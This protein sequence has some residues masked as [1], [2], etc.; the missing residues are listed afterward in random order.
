MSVIAGLVRYPDVCS[1]FAR[2][3][4]LER[5]RNRLANISMGC[6]SCKCATKSSITT[7]TS[8]VGA[9]IE[10][11]HA[12]PP[13]IP[14]HGS[15]ETVRVPSYDYFLSYSYLSQKGYYPDAPEKANQDSFCIET[16]LNNN[17]DDHFF[18]VFD[19]HGQFGAQCS[20]FAK[21]FLIQNL[22]KDPNFHSDISEAMFA[23]FR[24][25]N[26][27]L[28][29]DT[30]IDDSMS[31]TT[32]ITVLVHGKTLYVANV[33]DSRAVLA[34][35]RGN[36]LLAMDL[37]CDQTPFRVDEYERVKQCGARVLS[38]DQLEGLKDPAIQNWGTEEDADDGGDPPRLW[39]PNGNYPGTAFTRSIGDDT[40]ET[41]GVTAIPEIN[42]V[43]LT[44]DNPF[45][46]VASDGVFEFLSS[47]AVVD[48]VAK[49]KDPHE[50]CAA[51][52]TESHRLWLQNETRTDDIT[53]I[54]VQIH[55]LKNTRFRKTD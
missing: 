21:K 6:V 16:S 12:H 19:G 1:S 17:P 22:V 20:Q 39:V 25:T 33:G 24:A 2:I 38:L 13:L 54:I 51:I 53:I 43:E 35:R 30:S 27:Q 7:S 40:A 36:D 52:A 14:S 18:A 3:S 8:S 9:E 48:M 46:V 32:A 11:L 26:A 10:S 23:A 37:S 55:G 15:V 31:G 41:I 50:A 42:I 44:P 5:R 28:H 49:C 45:F 4:R 47:Q 34:Q 29:R